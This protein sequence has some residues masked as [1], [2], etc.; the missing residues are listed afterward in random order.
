MMTTD[1]SG[2]GVGYS[3]ICC[4]P[5][6]DLAPSRRWGPSEF[7]DDS[8]FELLSFQ[9]GDFY[10]RALILGRKGGAVFDLFD[11]HLDGSAG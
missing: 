11:R 6:S 1:E 3:A 10:G 9:L 7:R 2:G 5:R 4:Q 8:S